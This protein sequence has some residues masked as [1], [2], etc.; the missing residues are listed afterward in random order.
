MEPSSSPRSPFSEPHLDER[1]AA[2]L[3]L[4]RAS[5]E[6]LDNVISD[7][8]GPASVAASVLGTEAVIAAAEALKARLRGL[9]R[10]VL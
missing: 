7:S 10:E 4:L 9:S 8:V 6:T 3:N 1:M 5:V 2:E